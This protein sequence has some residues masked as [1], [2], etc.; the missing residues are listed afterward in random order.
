MG[1][2]LRKSS[3]DE[4]RHQSDSISKAVDRF[5]GVL[6]SG[7]PVSSSLSD[8]EQHLDQSRKS[9]SDLSAILLDE[10]PPVPKAGLQRMAIALSRMANHLGIAVQVMA[11]A[12]EV[13]CREAFVEASVLL[14]DALRL[15]GEA[16]EDLRRRG[17]ESRST[18]DLPSKIRPL[19]E[20][21]QI[22]AHDI[23]VA[24]SPISMDGVANKLCLHLAADRL[25]DAA[26][27]CGHAAELIAI[28]VSDL[29]LRSAS[30][31]T[32]TY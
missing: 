21:A 15:V 6:E 1:Q 8:I 11:S 27:V 7:A 22:I 9:R 23:R 16:V 20:A 14:V 31:Q 25:S 18:R 10:V 19:I 5:R 2:A 13:A 17:V 26:R 12:E 3:F 30:D 29:S 4:L 32:I 28:L 24:A